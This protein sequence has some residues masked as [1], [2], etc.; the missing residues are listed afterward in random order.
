MNV[1]NSYANSGFHRCRCLFKIEFNQ[2]TPSC[3]DLL[4]VINVSSAV[5][6]LGK[7]GKGR[8]EERRAWML[9]FALLLVYRLN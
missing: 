7:V 8:G 4:F 2:S 9:H 3:G 6:C 5:V 1:S